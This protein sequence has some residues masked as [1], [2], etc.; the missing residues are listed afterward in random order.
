M[1]MRFFSFKAAVWFSKLYCFLIKAVNM[2]VLVCKSGAS[3]AQS[4]SL[5]QWKVFIEV[6][7]D[8]R[9]RNWDILK[10]TSKCKSNYVLQQSQYS[11]FESFLWLFSGTGSKSLYT[12]EHSLRKSALLVFRNILCEVLFRYFA[13]YYYFLLINLV[14]EGNFDSFYSFHNLLTVNSPRL[15]CDIQ[16]FGI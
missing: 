13:Q 11:F 10:Q 2:H 7:S 3:S 5:D 16:Y 4:Y 9:K 1:C 15:I 8:F 6:K 14:S 12:H